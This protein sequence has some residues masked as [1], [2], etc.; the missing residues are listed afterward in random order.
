MAIPEKP[1]VDG[2][3]ANMMLFF[4]WLW[5]R[6]VHRWIHAGFAF[7][8]GT[9]GNLDGSLNF[10]FVGGATLEANFF[11]TIHTEGAIQVKVYQDP[12]IGVGSLGT[13]LAS[14]NCKRS[15]DTVAEGT[16]FVNPG[17]ADVGTR[18]PYGMIAGG[19]GVGGS[20]SGGEGSQ[21]EETIQKVRGQLLITLETGGALD[22]EYHV[23]WY[24]ET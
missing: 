7:R 3:P 19:T 15:S 10:L 21:R 22:Y 12:T 13:P 18:I 14:F 23:N 5:Q 24:E 6:E 1:A 20:A 8:S 2:N 9:W 11:H 4:D 16:L 17:I